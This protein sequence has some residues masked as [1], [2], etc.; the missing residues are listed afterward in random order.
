M[1]AK[2]TGR[3]RGELGGRSTPVDLIGLPE[4]AEILGVHYM[5]AYRYVRTGRLPATS[6][7]GVWQIDPDDVLAAVGAAPVPRR[8][9][10]GSRSKAATRLERRLVQGDSGGAFAVC[11]EAIASWATPEDVYVD[12]VVPAMRS[13]G[14]RW[15]DGEIS[16]AVEHRATTAVVGVMGRLGPRFS[17]SGRK[18]GT[19]VIGAPA[20]ERHSI[21]VT[22]VADM[23]RAERFDVV[24]LGGDTPTESF[25]EAARAADRLVAVAIGVTTFGNGPAVAAAVH[26]LHAAVPG[27]PVIV[28]GAAVPTR[29]AATRAGADQWSGTDGRRLVELVAI[30]MA[31]GA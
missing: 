1:V 8:V 16:V 14:D 29:A 24:D 9:Q 17:R 26:A 7:G 6:V 11:E 23:L 21:P 2:Q 12:M 31:E 25:V 5:T 20:G 28:G 15:H 18:R 13:I 22:L 19:M 10:G 27:S 4:A 30:E 3:N